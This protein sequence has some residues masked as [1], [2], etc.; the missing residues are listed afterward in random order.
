VTFP[1]HGIV[2]LESTDEG[3]TYREQWRLT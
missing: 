3:E 2:A 1:Q